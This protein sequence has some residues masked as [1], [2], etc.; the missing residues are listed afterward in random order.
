V[1]FETIAGSP[2]GV[3]VLDMLVADEFATERSIGELSEA[4][5]YEVVT[6][7][8]E[9]VSSEK[10]SPAPARFWPWEDR[11]S[12][13]VADR[14]ARAV[15]ASAGARW[16]SGVVFDRPQV[17]LGSVATTPTAGIVTPPCAGKPPTAIWTSSALAGEPSAWWP[18]VRNG[19]DGSPPDGPQSIWR[20]TPQPDARVFE[21][22]AP[23]DWQWLCESFPGPDRGAYA[24]P[25]WDAVG[26]AFDG[27][28]LTVEGLIRTQGVAVA[29]NRGPAMLE[30]W[31]AEATAWL[32]WSVSSLERLGTIALDRAPVERPTREIRRGL[33]RA[34]RRSRGQTDAYE[35]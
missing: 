26:N 27:L 25:D 21:I 5:L 3:R 15:P 22:R 31:D 35:R 18:V 28:H 13:E 23:S 34:R 2:V 7:A 8:A 33:R 10:W 24:A 17:W 4:A 14:I 19:A 6:E 1:S 11:V 16:W 32:R 29:T 20:I 9:Q 30:H 12:A